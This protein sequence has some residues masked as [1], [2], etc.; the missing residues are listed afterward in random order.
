MKTSFDLKLEQDEQQDPD[1]AAAFERYQDPFVES[2][3]VFL[4][5]SF[6]QDLSEGFSVDVPFTES[7]ACTV[8]APNYEL[9]LTRESL[10]SLLVG[11]RLELQEWAAGSNAYHLQA[12]LV[13]LV[14][15]ELTGDDLQTQAA[16]MQE[17]AVDSEVAYYELAMLV[18]HLVG[19]F[20][21]LETLLLRSKD[22]MDIVNAITP[23]VDNHLCIAK[24]MAAD[25]L[26]QSNLGLKV[27]ANHAHILY[28][29]ALLRL[30]DNIA[31]CAYSLNCTDV[32][33]FVIYKLEKY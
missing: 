17:L 19:A 20:A 3:T 2:Y 4:A 24:V 5:D 29:T 27:V 6:P 31:L 12:I 15:G 28:E 23:A 25:C 7:V 9:A 21:Q 32:M 16:C 10:E 1:W 22:S 14:S 8:S 33:E 13:S 30:R 11:P 26:A 18:K